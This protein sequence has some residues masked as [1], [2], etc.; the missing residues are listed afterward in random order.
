MYVSIENTRFSNQ[1]QFHINVSK[2]LDLNAI[3]IPPLVIQPFIENALWHGLSPKEGDK[4]LKINIYPKDNVHFIIEIIDNGIGRKRAAEIKEARTFKR[5]SV[6]IKLS[7]ER[8]KHFSKTLKNT[9][10]ITFVDLYD[11]NGKPTGT[12]VII[13]IPYK[14]KSTSQNID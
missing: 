14:K 3:V 13:E 2:K 7:E 8:L 5:E 1:I 12:K 6:G 4:I 10:K 9:F 11:E